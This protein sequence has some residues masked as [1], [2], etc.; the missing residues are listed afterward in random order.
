MKREALRQQM[1]VRA[2]WRDDAALQGWVRAPARAN[3]AQGLAAYRA[4]AGA[5][6]ERALRSAFP[7][8]AAL[9]GDESFAALARHFWQRHAP[10]SGDVGAWGDALPAFIA[11]SPQLADE[12]YLADSAR[13]DWALHCASRA[14]DMADA[15]DLPHRL[16]A[17]AEADPSDVRLQ[18]APGA[19]VLSSRFPIVSIWQ[20]HQGRLPFDAVRAAFESARGEHAFA[21]RDAG[22]VLQVEA[23][24]RAD[25]AFTRAV[26]D[27]RTLAAA[28]DA[29]GDDFAFDRWL[30]RAL[31]A[32]WLMD[33]LTPSPTP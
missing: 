11:D 27:Q 9:V 15:P 13:L 6:A 30:A 29:A 16:A 22:F 20:A 5:L 18:L 25:A 28:L 3:T 24:S 17:L 19:A 4:N 12:P 21:W 2:L 33:L 8:I 10:H 31:G 7:T 14:A 26:L 1:L 23:L 32:R